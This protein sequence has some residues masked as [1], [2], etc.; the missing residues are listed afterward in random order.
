MANY[1][2]DPFDMR[3]GSRAGPNCRLLGALVMY[4]KNFQ[5][6]MVGHTLTPLTC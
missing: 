6:I 2:C 5:L 3:Q 1:V 4:A